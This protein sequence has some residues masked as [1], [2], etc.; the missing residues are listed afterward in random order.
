MKTKRKMRLSLLI[1]AALMMSLVI[2]AS[3]AFAE[4]DEFEFPPKE[5]QYLDENGDMQT[6]PKSDFK[7]FGYDASINDPLGDG[8]YVMY[9]GALM[10]RVRVS[11]NAKI[12]LMDGAEMVFESGINVP[13]NTSLSIYAQSADKETAGKLKAYGDSDYSGIG[14]DDS[15]KGIEN[16]CGTINVYGG[17][18]EATGGQCG[19]G[20]GGGDPY[21]SDWTMY[22]ANGGTFYMKAGWVTARGGELA[23]GIGGGRRGHSGT[24][25]IDGGVVEAYGGAA[26]SDSDYCGGAGIGG[27]EGRHTTEYGR[28]LVGGSAE[29]ITINGGTVTAEGGRG[30]AGIGGGGYANGSKSTDNWIKITGGKVFATG[31]EKGGA[32]IGGGIG[33]LNKWYTGGAGANVEISGG[34]VKATGGDEAAGIGATRS[35]SQGSGQTRIKGGTVVAQGGDYAAGIGTGNYPYYVSQ[36]TTWTTLYDIEISGDADVTA[37]GGKEGAGIGCGNEGADSSGKHG[38]VKIS[39]N[40]VVKATGGKYGAGIGGGDQQ[41]NGTVDIMGGKVTAQGGYGAA[42]IG[43]GDDINDKSES[44]DVIIS[45]GTVNATGG[46]FGAGIG[47]ADG[48]DMTGKITITG[49][50][51]T[52]KAT[53][54]AAGIGGGNAW[55][56]HGG[57]NCG[58]VSIDLKGQDDFVLALPDDDSAPIG[59]GDSGDSDGTLTLGNESGNYMSVRKLGSASDYETVMKENPVAA[60]GRT[61]AC[62]SDSNKAVLIKYCRD[63]QDIDEADRAGHLAYS[64]IDNDYHNVEC[65]YC[66]YAEKEKH[67]SEDT[68]H[69]EYCTKCGGEKYRITFKEGDPAEVNETK[70]LEVTPKTEFEFPEPDEDK[71]PADMWFI[72][73]GLEDVSGGETLPAKALRTP[74]SD[75]VWV[76]VYGEA[77]ISFDPGGGSGQMP[78]VKKKKGSEYL[79]P[80]NKFKAPEGKDFAGWSDG[81]DIYQ[82]NDPEHPYTVNEI[83]ITFTAQWKAHEHSMVPHEAA[84]AKCDK[85]GNIKYYECKGCNSFFHDEAGQNEIAKGDTVIP[86]TGHLWGDT[87][88]TWNDNNS[89]VTTERVCNND[90]AHIET[91]T[92]TSKPATV[93]STC[94]KEGKTVYTAEF[95]NDAFEKQTRTVTIDK[96]PHTWSGDWMADP[97]DTSQ[98]FRVCSVCDYKQTRDHKHALT[99]IPEKAAGC[100]SSGVRKHWECQECG[101]WF[102]DGEGNQEVTAAS[103]RIPAKGHKFGGEVRMDD[104]SGYV[105][106]TCTTEGNYNTKRTCEN[107]NYV[108]IKS[109]EIPALG[110]NWDAGDVTEEPT[111]T[112]AGSR[113]FTCLNGCGET[114]TEEVPASGHQWRDWAET[115]PATEVAAGEEARECDVCHERE[116]RIIPILNHEHKLSEVEKKAAT[117]TENGNIKY[118]VCDQGDYPCQRFFADGEAKTEIDQ[119]QIVIRASG[120]DY[121]TSW[122]WGEGN[123]TAKLEYHCENCGDSGAVEAE[124]TAEETETSVRY[125]AVARFEGRRY[126]IIRTVRLTP[127]TEDMVTLIPDSFTYNGTVQ[128]PETV[129]VYDE[130]GILA[131]E[132]KYEASYSDEESIHAGTY[133]VVVKGL[134]PFK[135]EVTK[136]YTI[137]KAANTLTVKAKTAKVKAKK[138][139]KKAQ[140][141]SVKK[142]L[143]VSGAQGKVTYKKV[144][145][146]KKIRINAK[147]GK[148]TVK[149][150]LKKGTY[151]VKVKVTAAGNGDYKP[152]TKQVTFKVK[153]K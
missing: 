31:G 128:K 90:S 50:K 104:D 146:N 53:K 30:A 13:E 1:F 95:K 66:D 116:T 42:G 117:C 83:E 27:G 32:G 63:C 138:L 22:G 62:Q 36:F 37:T 35:K 122:T 57:G 135:G 127:L 45:G 14:G 58:E 145:G 21:V 23:A 150:K 52:A 49:G 139:K 144:K 17:V 65:P 43:S 7:V 20:I 16:K 82:V 129:D 109:H 141:L 123:R 34:Y 119:A 48:S 5:V 140:K 29:N 149:K 107:C 64:K 75:E 120:H 106:P 56:S 60:S 81:T 9:T 152:L 153:V 79:L 124:V 143:K 96:K 39:G 147:T 28:D 15:V 4:D 26:L 18:I 38:K 101:K 91:E 54:E 93:D 44:A 151:K 69:P 10:Q 102:A 25:T 114:R 73:W 89:E 137:G 41:V 132:D 78:Q 84:P 80:P 100:T 19:A 59:H 118:W 86:A 67:D 126:T 40:A 47:G 55:S 94:S 105:A 131:A 24:I 112:Q 142:V 148:V 85:A 76:A 87:K 111:C 6:L 92:V 2:S 77:V 115:E 108:Q 134:L 68:Q 71:I 121:K 61:G 70:A 46:E 33:P 97:E 8:W 88:Y 113:L 98:D 130:N 3:A 74:K 11:G 125:K 136:T 12:I 99:E 133:T 72:G 103:W 51:V 110:H